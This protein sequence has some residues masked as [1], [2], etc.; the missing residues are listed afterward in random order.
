MRYTMS[1]AVF[2]LLFN[3]TASAQQRDT[4]RAYGPG[5]PLPAMKEAAQ[6]FGKQH[7]VVVEVTGGPTTQWLARAK[8]DADIIFSGSEHM[9]TDFVKA[10]ENRIDE[11][12]ITPLYLRASAILV[13]PGNPKQIT[14]FEDLLKGGV[15]LLVVNGAG[16]TGLWEDM[17][18]MTGDI[19][20][21][22]KL[23]SNIVHFAANSGDAKQKWVADKTIDA[24]IIWTI[25]QVANPQL[26][27]LVPPGKQWTIHRDA[28]VTLTKRAG[29]NGHARAFAQF[30]QSPEGAAIFRKWGWL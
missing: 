11:K 26:A 29:Q 12:T 10:M 13:R 9:M 23:R 27:D 1:V 20:V 15:R 30:L 8:R 24:W 14:G 17:A 28:G 3:A 22:R 25:W 16:Q 19:T 4:I 18:G 5:G 2:A 21:V 6:A 7:G